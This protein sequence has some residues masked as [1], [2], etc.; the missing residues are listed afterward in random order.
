[1]N[2]ARKV[3]GDFYEAT[4]LKKVLYCAWTDSKVILQ[5]FKNF[6]GI[7]KITIKTLQVAKN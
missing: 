3:C 7:N 2:I 4:L 1:L 6:V 5:G